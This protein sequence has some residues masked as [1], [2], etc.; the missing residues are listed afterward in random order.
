MSEHN[1]LYHATRHFFANFL[2]LIFVLWCPVLL[3]GACIV[4]IASFSICMRRVVYLFFGAY[5]NFFFFVVGDFIRLLCIFG[6]ERRISQIWNP[7]KSPIKTYAMFMNT[8]HTHSHIGAFRS[9]I[10]RFSWSIRASNV[11]ETGIINFFSVIG[12][13]YNIVYSHSIWIS[14]DHLK[15]IF[16]LILT[17]MIFM[18]RSLASQHHKNA[19]I[20]AQQQEQHSDR[21]MRSALFFCLRLLQKKVLP[22]GSG[23][24]HPHIHTKAKTGRSN[25]GTDF[26]SDLILIYID[27]HI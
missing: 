8:S 5:H 19:M 6:G 21:R 7:N 9:H 4:A 20:F 22:S 17:I 18:L 3:D 23:R 27:M 2:S 24:H 14:N 1:P 25:T 26:V 16:A 10:S 12:G 11:N 13:G 15:V